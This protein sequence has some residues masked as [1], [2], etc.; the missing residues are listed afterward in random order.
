MSIGL[1]RD[2][3]LRDDR[4]QAIASATRT[5][6]LEA[7]GLSA[8]KAALAGDLVDGFAEAIAI[9]RRNLPTMPEQVAQATYG[10]M[11]SP[12][13]GFQRK[14]R[15]DED[16]VRTVLRLRSK[17]AEPKKTL[18]D[19]SKYYDDSFYREAMR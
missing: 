3:L 9:L 17:Y 19:P 10:V 7:E 6:Q 16:G 8:L 14:A 5:L 11:L 15:I 1:K 18:T 4:G 13:D 12:T 2:R